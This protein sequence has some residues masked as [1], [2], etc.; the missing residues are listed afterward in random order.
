MPTPS[1]NVEMDQQLYKIVWHLTLL[2]SRYYHR[3]HNSQNF[4]LLRNQGHQHCKRLRTFQHCQRNRNHQHCQCLRVS[5]VDA[6]LEQPP[7]PPDVQQQPLAVQPQPASDERPA[8]WFLDPD[9]RPTLAVENASDFR[10]PAGQYHPEKY[11]YAP[12]GHA[13]VALGA[14]W[15]TRYPGQNCPTHVISFQNGQWTSWS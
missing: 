5:R 4:Q 11:K 1:I 8:G 13:L 2:D 9:G 15:R 7:Q 6:P 10:T 14:S 3:F 12:A